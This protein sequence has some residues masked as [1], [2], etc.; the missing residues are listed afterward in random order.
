MYYAIG[1]GNEPLSILTNRMLVASLSSLPSLIMFIQ[2]QQIIKKNIGN[3]PRYIAVILFLGWPF[4]FL[5]Y[6]TKGI[7][8]IILVFA[9]F[10]V[11]LRIIQGRKPF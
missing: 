11:L 3:L 4:G 2:G 6:N 8:H 10:V 9:I 1:Y 5:F 7:I